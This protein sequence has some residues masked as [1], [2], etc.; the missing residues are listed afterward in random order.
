L[1][2]ARIE[3]TD[4]ESR[5]VV[6]AAH[7]AGSGDP[8]TIAIPWEQWV[9]LAP[10]Q[11]VIEGVLERREEKKQF[12]PMP[13]PLFSGRVIW[14]LSLPSLY[15]FDLYL[16]S[17]DTSALG[18]FVGTAAPVFACMLWNVFCASRPST[19]FWAKA[20]LDHRNK[21]ARDAPAQDG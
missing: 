7:R 20:T 13:K 15:F 1:P 9:D 16:R 8:V 3:P 2:H 5:R 17:G 18:A 12:D 10:V 14:W 19:W 6:L 11:W 21:P 4:A